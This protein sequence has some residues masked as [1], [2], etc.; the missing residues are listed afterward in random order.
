MAGAELLLLLLLLPVG[1]PFPAYRTATAWANI[2]DPPP[3]TAAV[4][5]LP[6][7]TL[8]GLGCSEPRRAP[9]EM[10]ALSGAEPGL[11]T[12]WRL[13][14]SMAMGGETLE[15]RTSAGWKGGRAAA[16]LE[17]DTLAVDV[18]G[19]D[20]EDCGAVSD[21]ARAGKR[22]AG[23]E[24]WTEID[25][26]PPSVSTG[27]PKSYESLREGGL[28]VRGG[29]LVRRYNSSLRSLL[30][31]SGMSRSMAQRLRP[32]QHMSRGEAGR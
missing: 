25:N 20:T 23:R 26:L 28:V 19:G 29:E 31:N 30:Q 13:G 11:L 18:A 8:V 9:E 17:P 10:G 5:K 24:N 12:E 14:G 22:E 4:S 32:R 15:S 16:L 1:A 27:P 7:P 6:T 2:R 3:K 21:G